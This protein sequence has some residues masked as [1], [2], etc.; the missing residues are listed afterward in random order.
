MTWNCC[1]GDLERKRPPI[2][3]LAPDLAVLQ[4]CARPKAPGLDSLWFGDDPR[5]GIAVIARNGFSVRAARR[6]P[7]VPR[8]CIPL[9]VTGPVE[10][11]LLAVWALQNPDYPYVRGLHRAIEIYR[12]RIRARPTVIAGDFNSNSF[13][14][15]KRPGAKDHGALVRELAKLGLESGYHSYFGE[16]HGQETRP[17]FYFQWNENRPYHLDYCFL[18]KTWLGRL[19]HAE[20]GDFAGWRQWSDHRPVVIDVEV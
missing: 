9:E 4:E 11:Q 13:W 8:W 1:R 10:F 20:V 17:T 15:K 3:A 12:R 16:E 6:N 18:P 7:G 2:E 19:R 14:D 5:K